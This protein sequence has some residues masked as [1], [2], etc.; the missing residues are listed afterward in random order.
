MIDLK[1][2]KQISQKHECKCC[3][4]KDKKKI[5][6]DKKV[7]ERIKE[8]KWGTC[9]LNQTTLIKHNSSLYTGIIYRP[10]D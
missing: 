8:S 5:A 6:Q 1:I 3:Q 2:Q 9:F 7:F 10:S 4:L